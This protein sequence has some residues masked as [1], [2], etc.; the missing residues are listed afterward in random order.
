VGQVSIDGEK[1]WID[2][3]LAPDGALRL[4][5]EDAGVSLAD[6]AGPMQLVGVLAMGDAAAGRA[7]GAG[8]VIGQDCGS[9]E[10][11]RFCAQTASWEVSLT[12][13]GPYI[14][15]GAEGPLVVHTSVGDE[16]WAID[17]GY[18]GGRSGFGESVG[19]IQLPSPGVF[20]ERDATFARG[21]EVIVNLDAAGL[22]FFQS[23]ET[24]CTGNGALRPYEAA[25][26]RNLY[27]IELMIASCRSP[28]EHLN[29]AF[30]G[31][32]TFEGADPWDYGLERVF[33]MWLSSNPGA[34]APA[35]LTLRA[36]NSQ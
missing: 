31:L 6:V 22:F 26:P 13:S 29:A 27:R 17:T 5:V 3:V 18:W 8:I 19:S 15:G 34:P 36:S 32:S 4:D 9:A 10:P 28:L 35:A 7:P 33:K 11:S 20:S 12:T 21:G 24:G 2:G 25:V 30:E 16:V 1:H 14:D 23:A